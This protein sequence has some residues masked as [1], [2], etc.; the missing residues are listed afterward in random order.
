MASS[1]CCPMALTS[2]PRDM[3]RA[4]QHRKSYTST[5]SGVGSQ[6]PGA[7]CARSGEASARWLNV[8]LPLK[9][10]VDHGVDLRSHDPTRTWDDG[11][12]D[13]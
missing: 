13:Q 4:V 6:C 12:V 11:Y 3:G 9:A 10:F 7:D 2:A 1:L 5:Q 8:L